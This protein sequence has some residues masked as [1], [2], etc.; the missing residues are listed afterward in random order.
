MILSI[1]GICFAQEFSADIVMTTAQGSMSGKIFAKSGK[2][3]METNQVISIARMDLGV[4]WMLLPGQKMYMENPLN[5]QDIA[6]AAQDAL[7]EKSLLGQEQANGKTVDKYKVVSKVSGKDYVMYQW[8]AR[9]SKIPVKSQAADGSWSQEYNNVQEGP[10]PDSLFELPG[11]Y[12]KLAMPSADEL[13]SGKGG[14][15]L[16]KSMRSKE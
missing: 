5:A 12:A 16:P 6:S 2:V 10:Q 3:R 4:T 15:K 13:M 8:I 1:S 11:G 14:I 9:D 7:G